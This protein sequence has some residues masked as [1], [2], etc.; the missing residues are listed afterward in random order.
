MICLKAKVSCRAYQR[1]EIS[2]IPTT[3]Q[4]GLIELKQAGELFEQLVNRVKPLQEDGTLLAHIV[5]VL[6]VATAVPKLM[7]KVQPLRLYQ[8]LET[9]QMIDMPLSTMRATTHI[10]V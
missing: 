3:Y 6:L 9:L 7:T 5:G 4:E 2:K 10:G 8:H 1:T